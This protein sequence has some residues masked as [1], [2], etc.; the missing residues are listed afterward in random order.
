VDLDRGDYEVTDIVWVSVA[1]VDA[2][3]RIVSWT[4]TKAESLG[5]VPIPAGMREVFVGEADLQLTRQL[6]WIDE[7]NTL[8]PRPES[9]RTFNKLSVAADGVDEAVMSGLPAGSRVR[10]EGPA[11]PMYFETDSVGLSLSFNV[12]GIYNVWVEDFPSL[13]KEFA[14][15]ATE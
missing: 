12:P 14:I 15:E 2:K 4:R 10:I 3:G 11:G 1:T 6:F 5:L 9:T 7:G 13:P 8:T